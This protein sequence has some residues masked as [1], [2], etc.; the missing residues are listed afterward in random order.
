MDHKKRY[1][2]NA[3]L[4]CI[5]FGDDVRKQADIVLQ[6]NPSVEKFLNDPEVRILQAFRSK[7]SQEITVSINVQACD[8]EAE[9]HLLKKGKGPIPDNIESYILVMSTLESPLYSLFLAI[10]N[11]YSPKLLGTGNLNLDHKI[12]QTLVDLEKELH[13]SILKNGVDQKNASELDASAVES[14]QHEYQYWLGLSKQEGHDAERAQAFLKHLKGEKGE[15][16][17]LPQRFEDVNECKQADVIM[18]IDDAQ[19][20]FNGLWHENNFARGTS[21]PKTR[22]VRLLDVIGGTLAAYIRRNL[23][24]F[25]LWKGP[26]TK[27][28]H[29]INSAVEL[30]A[31]WISTTDNLSE[32]DWRERWTGG[33]YVDQIILPFRTRLQEILV[34]RSVYEEMR[35]LLPKNDPYVDKLEQM[36]GIFDDSQILQCSPY[37]Q[38]EWTSTIDQLNRMLEPVESKVASLMKS[39]LSSLSG[40]PRSLVGELRGFEYLF[41][42]PNISQQLQS[43]TSSLL[44]RFMSHIDELASQFSSQASSF[45]KD[46]AVEAMVWANQMA[47]KSEQTC[48]I[49]ARVLAKVSGVARLTEANRGLIKQIQ[50]FSGKHFQHW[51]SALQTNLDS[52]SQ[53]SAE[54]S[55]AAMEVV[56]TQQSFFQVSFH[57]SF[58]SLLD[59]MRLV[60]GLGNKLPSGLN[61]IF[62]LAE[63]YFHQG[64]KL[65]QLA[66]FYNTTTKQIIPSQIGMLALET[67]KFQRIV[68]EKQAVWESPGQC[69]KFTNRLMSAVEELTSRNRR[70]LTTHVSLS[71]HI[72]ELMSTDLLHKREEWLEKLKKLQAM[73]AKEERNADAASM[74]LWRNHWDHQLYKAFEIQYRTCLETLNDN[75][76]DLQVSLYFSRKQLNFR[77]PLEDLRTKYYRNL[78]KFLDLPKSF[79]GLSNSDL[80]SDI[81]ERNA[82]GLF[83][84]YSNAETLF[85]QLRALIKDYEHWVVLGTVDIEDYVEGTLTEVSQYEENFKLIERKHREAQ[86]IPEETKVGCITVNFSAFKSAVDDLMHRFSDAM[87]LNLRKK[88]LQGYKQLDEYLTQAMDRLNNRP[89][90]VDE[91]AKAKTEWRDLSSRKKEMVALLRMV[92]ANNRMLNQKVSMPLDLSGLRPRWETFVVG[93]EAFNDM[94]DDQR[95]T[96]KGDIEKRLQESRSLIDKFTSRWR[97]AKPQVTGTEMTQEIANKI[98]AE[99]DE[100]NTEL[101]T[102][103]DTVEEIQRDADAFEMQKPTFGVLDEAKEE[104]KEHQSSWS[105]YAEYTSELNGM[106]SEAWVAFRARI[107]SFEDFLQKW[108]GK[109][110]D[111]K[112]DMVF[113]FI[114]KEIRK[115]RLTWPVLRKVT[116]ELFEAEHWKLLFAKIKI[117]PEVTLPTLTLGHFLSVHETII[118]EQKFLDHL[119]ARAQGEVTIRDAVDELKAWAENTNFATL[120][121]ETVKGKKTCLI[122]D[123][124]DLFTKLSDQASLVGSLKE[125]PYFPPFADQVKEFEDKIGL[126]DLCLHDINQIQRKWVYLEPIFGRGALPSEQARFK[127]IDTEFRAI[128]DDVAVNPNVVNMA[129]IPNL[130]DSVKV[131]LDQ[132][133]RCQKA[134]NDFLEEKRA[135]FPRFYF[136]GDDDLLE[137][138]GQCQNPAVI[139]NHLKKLFAGIFKVEFSQDN[140]TIVA[141]LSSAGEKVPLLNPVEITEKVEEWLF[142]LSSAM[143]ETL[144]ASVVQ[145]RTEGSLAF[146]N[147]SSQVICVTDIVRFTAETEN[148]IKQGKLQA[149]LEKT[150]THLQ[151][152][153]AIESEDRL[154]Q[155][156]IQAL[157]LD[158]IHNVDVVELLVQKNVTSTDSWFWQKQLRFYLRKDGR[159][160]VTMCDAEF[161]YSYEY[162][163]NAAK[164]VHTPL[165]D[166][167]YLVLTQGMHLGYGGNPYGPAG[168]G[169]TESV[170][171]LGQALGRQV[172]VFNC[173]EG[174]DFQSMGRIFTGLVKSGAW[175]CFDEFNR[176]KEDQLSAVSQQIQV[177]QA[178][179]K[180]GDPSADLLGKTIDVNGNAA[181]F[182]TMNPASKEYGGRSKLPHNLK[183]LFRAVAMSVPDI[184]LIAE[185]ILYSEGFNFAKE[186]GH[187]LTQVYTLSQQLLSPQIHY[188]WGLRALKTILIHAGRLVRQERKHGTQ[189]DF[190]LEAKLVI[191][192]LR[193]NTLSKLTYDDSVRFNGLIEDVFPGIKAE[194]IEYKDLELAIRDCIAEMKLE[195]VEAQIKKILQLNEAL[196]QRMGVVVV[197]PS[198]CGK[199]VMLDVLHK[200][201]KK[202]GQEVV[203]HFMNPKALDREKLLGHM[204]PDTRE[205]FDGVLTAAARQV[206]REPTDVNSWVI[207]D[208]DIDPEWVESLN[209]VLDDN[210]LLTMPNGERIK[211]GTNVNFVFETH[212]LSFASPATVSR[213]GMIFLS[214]ENADVR[215]LV[216]AWIRK[217][218]AKAQDG[219]S[220]LMDAMFYKALDWVLDSNALVVATTKVGVVLTAL[221]H[222]ENIRSKG[223]FVVGLIR[224]MGSNLE[225]AKR[226]VFAQQIFDWSG[227]RAPERHAPLDCFW[228]HQTKSFQQFVHEDKKIPKESLLA[229]SPPII[230][231]VDVQRN[232]ALIQPW[233]DSMKPFILVGPE[234]CGKSLLLLN[235][236]KKLKSTSVA[237]IYCSSQTVATHVIQ[238]LNDSCNMFSTNKG[239]CLRPKEG[240]RLILFLK[241]LNLPKPDKYATIQ[242]IAFLQ[243]LITYQG[244]HDENRDWI[245]IEG[246]QI[247]GSMNPATTVGRSALSTRF[248]AI[249]SV[250]YMTYPDHEQLESVYTCFLKGVFSLCPQ[251]DPHFSTD[252]TIRKLTATT[253]EVY[254]KLKRTFSPDDHRHY[255]F[256]PRDI[257]EWTFGLLRYDLASQSLLNVWAYEGNRLFCDRLVDR[258]SVRKFETIVSDILKTQ[259]N[260]EAKL[261][262]IYYTTLQNT[263]AAEPKAEEVAATREVGGTLNHIASKDFEALIAQSLYNYEREFKDL[264]MLLFP[265]ILDHIAFEDRV[266]S[267]PGGS[268]LLVGDSGVGRRTSITLVCFMKR[269]K[270]VSPTMSAAYNPKAFAADLKEIM[271]VAGVENK[272]VLLYLEDYQIVSESML[273]DINSLLAAGDVPGLFTPQEMEPLLGPIKEAFSVDGRFK[274][275]KDFFNYRIRTNLHIVLSMNPANDKFGIRCESNPAIYTKCTILWMGKW[276]KYGMVQVPVNRLKPIL[277]NLGSEINPKQLIEQVLFIHASMLSSGATPLKY[278]AFLDTHVK[279]FEENQTKLSTQQN[280]L[281]G[282][283]KKLS[284]AA[285]MVDVLSKDAAEKKEKVTAKQ[286]EADQALEMITQS[287]S[288]A[289]ERRVETQNLQKTLGVQEK[290]LSQRKTQIQDEL[291]D[292]QPIL[293]AAASAVGGIKK[294]NLSELRAFRMPPPAI[295]HVL[296]GVLTLMKEQDLSWN[297]MR[298]FLGKPSVKEGL[299]NFDA[300]TVDPETREKVQSLINKNAESFEA[301]KI[302]RVNVAAAPLASWVQANVKYAKVLQSIAPLRKEFDTATASLSSA[303]TRLTQCETELKQLDEQVTTLKT[304]FSETTSEAESLKLALQKTTEVLG[305]AQSL[306]G[307]LSGEQGRWKK[308]VEG[309]TEAL[310]QLPSHSLLAAAFVAYL[311][312]Q[313][314]DFRRRKLGEWKKRCNIAEFDLLTFLSSESELLKWKAEGLPSDSLSLQNGLIIENSKQCPL[315]IDPNAQATAWL[316]THLKEK[317]LEVVLQQEPRF[318]TTLELAV[319]FG[320]TLIVQEVDGAAPILYPLL[321]KDLS[322]QG[323]RFVVPV[324]EKIIDFN[325]NFSLYLVTRDPE[326][327]LPADTRA[328]VNEVNFTITRSGLEG[329]LLGITLNYEKPDLEKEKSRILAEEDNLK[330]K[331]AALEKSLLQEL[332]DS[333]GNI[334]E[335]KALILSLDNTKSQS[336]AIAEALANSAKL[337]VDLD[338]QREVYRPIAR[339]GSVLYFLIAQLSAVNNM[340]QFSLPGFNALFSKNLKIQT[341]QMAADE[342]IRVLCTQLKLMMFH[343]VTRSLF[344]ADRLMFGIHLINK[345]HPKFFQKNE[346]EF[347]KGEIV[348]P[349]NPNSAN[350]PSWATPDRKMAFSNF[351]NTFPDFLGTLRLNDDATWR[352]WATSRECENEFPAALKETVSP[353]QQLVLVSVFRPDRLQSAMQIFVCHCM[354]LPS[355]SPPPLNFETLV[356]EADALQPLLFITMAGSDPTQ[357]LE[358]FAA[359][360]IGR[361]KFHQL[362]MGSG[363]TDRAMEMLETACRDG[364]WLCLKNLHL[365]NSW[366]PHLEKKL[367]MLKPQDTFRLWLTTEPHESFPNILLQQSL[368]ITYESPP[369]VKQNLLRTFETWEP[370]YISKGSS[371]RAQLLFALAWFHAVVQERRTYVPQGFTKF[372]EFSFAD[373]RSG[374]DVID[375]I[376]ERENPQKSPDVDAGKLPWQTILGL[377]EFAI[378][379]GRIDNDHDVRVL[380]TYLAKYFNQHVLSAKGKPPTLKLNDGFE[381]PAS[382]KRDDFLRVIQSLPDTDAPSVF[383]LPANIEGALQQTLSSAVIIQL[384][385]LAVSSSSSNRFNREVWRT[386]LSSLIQLWDK[387]KEN[388]DLL[389]PPPKLSRAAEQLSPVDDFVVLEAEKCCELVAMVNEAINNIGNVI[390]QSGLLTP[391]IMSDGNALLNGET[392]WRWAKNWYGPSD[393]GSWIKELA[394]R[395][396]AMSRWIQRVEQQTLLSSPV[397]LTELFRPRIFLN[398]LRQQ[399]ARTTKKPID[400]LRLTASW[401]VSRL[402]AGASVRVNITDMLLQGAMFDNSCLQHLKEDSPTVSSLPPLYIAYVTKDDAEPYKDALAVPVYNQLSREE[403]VCEIRVPTR[404]AEDSDKFILTGCAIFLA[405]TK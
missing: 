10:H 224:G 48:S 53:Q 170:K 34:V 156:K 17:N 125:S 183:Q 120:E 285:A 59:E 150:R 68:K 181:I 134:L 152:L 356:A 124:K 318:V 43:E 165:T 363:Q 298:A 360:K 84:V 42:R 270:L 15:S 69:E 98:L 366:L 3:I 335:N 22:M 180:R 187:K 132:L 300:K 327:N 81:P 26:Y 23:S 104:V 341:N 331:L 171:A 85:D 257:T 352:A 148:A 47:Q 321:R 126:L 368:K 117:P 79:T 209:S 203:R 214:E 313:P 393:P 70:I 346:Y 18:L 273:E 222:L 392:P 60:V 140:N 238:K 105:L 353:F 242:M 90:S 338:Q 35:R 78:K 131:M 56:L 93:M 271:R 16:D 324:G 6:S 200:A 223:E 293:D 262:N 137:I 382:N 185:V 316:K 107:F 296:S 176:L 236:F 118:Q 145:C 289:S 277:S 221:S 237:P 139:Q 376:L 362:A 261:T 136:I 197:G 292:V 330:I 256:N 306:L 355:I 378:Y 52:N 168:T 1:I 217:Q 146:D 31:K 326:P 252:A 282:G 106:T 182:V 375:A 215:A 62:E 39:R 151:S 279:I 64:Q 163:G 235:M 400:S 193:I 266:L 147:Y 161:D 71:S 212:D 388:P 387:L 259:W 159:V 7:G 347:F 260:H 45:T 311:G 254:E 58:R 288:I 227:E 226:T 297:N 268:L 402:P 51:S 228:S 213:M 302:K 305:A 94:L 233:L 219:L 339:V 122:K 167:C 359:K 38:R 255:L 250:V 40:N 19:Q 160:T 405:S 141:M 281:S 179:L 367:K 365:V 174:I 113:D 133:E 247:V 169:K 232:E 211:F 397:S 280:H 205:W 364:H 110:K 166:K 244:F 77:P 5:G 143:E 380:V 265:E 13:N 349:D 381:V 245:S 95:E 129:G 208:G 358:D 130:K 153:T 11:I 345:L 283:L 301:E 234:G 320:K 399:T 192:A 398:A 30:C 216:S 175:G 172:L 310:T 74:Q 196:S 46:K 96:L 396:L 75:L 404:S 294:D 127:R 55:G 102:L 269:I 291:R 191:G 173:D 12:Q 315:I 323:P 361:E 135:R 210:R 225:I 401:D 128:M 54:M 350:L 304:K 194:D 248:T 41:L 49:V 63:G 184:A 36:F 44:N 394:T 218:P 155:L 82:E 28:K 253:V 73:F 164:L 243:Q 32:Q 14:V 9:V 379:G 384:R 29:A 27:V 80:Y 229:Q 202:Q 109:L 317:N 188:D 290:T 142:K 344:K 325:D 108:A 343:Y 351:A 240:D 374:A 67:Q 295:L 389:R 391:T 371:T 100:W 249:C 251:I 201:L 276:S 329:Q 61:K 287:M 334:L 308:Q 97:R 2:I 8:A 395:R 57:P 91:M 24:E 263:V 112:R 149:H 390:F 377:F 138:L 354:R 190:N 158:V 332:A 21:F 87:L 178:A 246:V 309:L 258:E 114:N 83:A 199:S 337:Q 119:A 65:K 239:R 340:Y 25:S 357:E 264:R 342:R 314:E 386:Q 231:T 373:L 267:R 116:G 92:N 20:A 312:D 186:V 88:T 103:C 101:K 403:F 189:I 204:D 274:Q 278:I 111:G 76:F 157:V 220:K 319:R 72:T 348:L 369:G 195:L 86:R 284:E 66:N 370:E 99:I 333:E 123:W 383:N 121:H 336:I 230:R 385:K 299:I 322:R 4:D 328:L 198:G 115:H 206:I 162:Q 50:E 303:R 89:E 241:D 33:K 372:Y 177:I 275:P 37:S 144:A 286:I 207:C 154:L 272:E 307:K